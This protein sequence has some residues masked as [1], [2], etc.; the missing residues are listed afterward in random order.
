MTLSRGTV[1]GYTVGALARSQGVVTFTD[2]SGDERIIL[3][4]GATVTSA[5]GRLRDNGISAI[6]L[7]GD[8]LTVAA[9]N[10]SSVMNVTEVLSRFASSQERLEK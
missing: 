9:W 5:G 6:T 1:R 3:R 7:D 8:V 10:S 4:C 2:A